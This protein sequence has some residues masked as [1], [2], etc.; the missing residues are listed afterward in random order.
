MSRLDE[1]GADEKQRISLQGP[2][3][4][5]GSYMLST[6]NRHYYYLQRC[7]KYKSL[8]RPKHALHAPSI[9]G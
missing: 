4:Y 8:A 5:K 7:Y 6:V 1:G 9:N 2:Y 3:C